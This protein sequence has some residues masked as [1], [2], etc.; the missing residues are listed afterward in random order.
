MKKIWRRAAATL[1]AL[2][3]LAPAQG[4]PLDAFLSARQDNRPWH[5]HL[6]AGYDLSNRGMDVFHLRGA[7]VAD[8]STLGNYHGAHLGGGVALTPRLWMDGMLWQRTIDTHAAAVKIDTWRLAGQYLLFEA[9][10]YRPALALRAGAW[11]D[12]TGEIVR[13]SAFAIGGVQLASARLS[14]VKDR[15]Y[16]LDAIATWQ[17]AAQTELNVFAGAGASRVSVGAAGATTQVG[18][19]LYQLSFGPDNVVGSCDSA[20]MSVRFTTPN[21][22][23]GLDF[24]K[25]FA[26]TARHFQGGFSLAWHD[27]HWRLR[28]GYQTLALK[29]DGVDDSIV[30]RGGVAYRHNHI[31]VGEVRRTLGAATS[32]FLR[33]QYMSNQFTGELP[34]AYNSLTANSFRQRYGIL[35]AGLIFSF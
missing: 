17:V 10:G 22:V 24:N 8:N 35:S 1:C 14:D 34:M 20:A 29:R 27:Q 7:D 2:Q 9:A 26:Y 23:F 6:E 25:E 15:Q 32:L 11:G 13:A 30:G 18:D 12:S 21:S 33:G 3:W 4:A 5:G 28:G 16:Q 19:C 31:L